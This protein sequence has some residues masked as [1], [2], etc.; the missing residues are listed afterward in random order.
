MKNKLAK[1]NFDKIMEISLLILLI[2]F[3]G[4]NVFNIYYNKKELEYKELNKANRNKFSMYIKDATGYIDYNGETFPEGYRLNIEKSQCEDSKG[5]KIT[6]IESVLSSDGLKI[7]VK[8][9]KTIYCK[10]YFDRIIIPNDFIYYIKSEEE[11]TKYTNSDT[12]TVYIK[13]ETE[14]ITNYCLTEEDGNEQCNWIETNGN[15][16]IETQYTFKDTTNGEKKIYAYLKDEYNSMSEAR[17]DGIIYDTTEPSCGT[18]NKTVTG[19][20]GVSGTLGCTD[21]LSDCEKATYSFSNLKG[22][23]NIVISDNASNEKTCTISV[24]AESHY[25]KQ[26]RNCKNCYYSS[27]VCGCNPIVTTGADPT[28]YTCT[29]TGGTAPSCECSG[30]FTTYEKPVNDC[31][32]WCSKEYPGAVGGPLDLD[33]CKCYVT[34]A[35]DSITYN[36]SDC[37]VGCNTWDNWSTIEDTT[38][39]TNGT[40]ST[41]NSSTETSCTFLY[42]VYY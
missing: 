15:K 14:N 25:K 9:K 38:I 8:S 34:K 30:Y 11:G 18:I 41:Q 33:G 10:L 29:S 13:Y 20:D 12:N 32:Y 2:M 17:E 5:V 6:P 21:N 7:T 40:S 22:N 35:C 16:E 3:V 23:T 28:A 19:R 31:T 27:L 36:G 39:C 1:L 26:S 42:S 4:V 37:R 24:R